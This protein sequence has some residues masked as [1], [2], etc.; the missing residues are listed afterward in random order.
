MMNPRSLSRLLERVEGLVERAE[1]LLPSAPPPSDLGAAPAFRWRAGRWGGHFHPVHRPHRISLADLHRVD[2]QK[3]ALDRNTRQFV[4]GHPANNAL[5]SGSR[6]TGKSSLVKAL[7]N[8]YEAEG[9][10]LVEVDK[11]DLISLPDI[12]EPLERRPERF[13]L[14]C[15][16][17]SFEAGEPGYTALKAVLDGSV[18]AAPDNVLLYATSNRRHLM[19]EYMRD[20]LDARYVGNEVHQSEA[21]EEKISLSERFGL[22]LSFHPFG[23]D[24]YLAAV[25]HWVAVL[26]GGAGAVGTGAAPRAAAAG[27]NPAVARAAGGGAAEAGAA[28]GD[29]AGAGGTAAGRGAGYGGADAEEGKGAGGAGEAEW[30]RVRAEALQWA[31]HRGSRSGRSAYQF[32]RDWAGR[33]ALRL[34][35]DA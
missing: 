18:S 17:L 14:F 10:R 5:L 12:L 16:D 3:E 26:D 19:P 8:E 11:Y 1:A 34:R 6:G 24:D 29:A 25:R 32:A 20:N 33:R 2:R 22:W 31:L 35:E 21:V 23:Q 7:L 4:R 28:G 9:L 15:D 27:A 30:E 13:I